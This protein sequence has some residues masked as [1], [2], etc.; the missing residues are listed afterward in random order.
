M[1]IKET[2]LSPPLRLLFFLLKRFVEDFAR[3]EEVRASGV[4]ELLRSVVTYF[5]AIESVLGLIWWRFED[6]RRC[7]SWCVTVCSRFDD[8][9]PVRSFF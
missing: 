6:L 4:G 3:A 5:D 7:A 9:K 8:L 2:P 1:R